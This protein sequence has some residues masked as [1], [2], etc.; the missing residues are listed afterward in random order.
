MILGFGSV[1]QEIFKRIVGFSPSEIIA[2]KNSQLLPDELEEL[3]GYLG[4]SSTLTVKTGEQDIEDLLC[5][6]DIV[7]ISST[8]T[9]STRGVVNRSFCTALKPGAVVVNI[10]RGQIVENEAMCEALNSGQVI[11]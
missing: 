6:V 5:D 11:C 10:A 1:G 3:R 9:E 2:L 4:G 7:I 8:L